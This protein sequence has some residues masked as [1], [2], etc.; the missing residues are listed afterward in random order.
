MKK[1]LAENLVRMDCNKNETNLYSTSEKNTKSMI[2]DKDIYLLIS[3]LKYI[4]NTDFEKIK[5]LS[6]YLKNVAN[7]LNMLELP[8][9][10]T[11]PTGLIIKQSYLETKSTSITPFMYSKIKLKLKVTIKDKYDKNKHLIFLIPSL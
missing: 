6:K 11:L 10:W 2:N 5:K 8:I 1:Y 4:I 9:T 7:L 3:C